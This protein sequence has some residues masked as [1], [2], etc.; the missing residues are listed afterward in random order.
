M[1]PADAVRGAPAPGRRHPRGRIPLPPVWPRRRVADQSDGDAAG[2]VAGR[3]DRRD[4]HRPAAARNGG[5]GGGG[6]GKRRVRG[7]G[8]GGGAR[9]EGCVDGGGFGGPRSGG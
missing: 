9:D 2:C 3:E 7:G 1:R 8:G 5:G 6:G 4:D